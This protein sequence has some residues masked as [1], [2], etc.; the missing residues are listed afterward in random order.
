MKL[1]QNLDSHPANTIAV[2]HVY[3]VPHSYPVY[4]ARTQLAAIDYQ[5]HKDRPYLLNAAGEMM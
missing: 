5:K 2:S 4:V 3:S 1:L